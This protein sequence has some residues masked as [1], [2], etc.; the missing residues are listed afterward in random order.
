[1]P[2]SIAV[3]RVQ[4]RRERSSLRLYNLLRTGLAAFCVRRRDEKEQRDKV[5][6][7]LPHKY[8]AQME[9]HG[10]RC[11]AC[12]YLCGHVSLVSAFWARPTSVKL[13]SCCLLH[14]GKAAK[15]ALTGTSTG[16]TARQR[17]WRNLKAV[18]QH[19]RIPRGRFDWVAWFRTRGSHCHFG[20]LCLVAPTPAKL[21]LPTGQW[22]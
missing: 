13:S 5:T 11:K 17:R 20:V 8:N 18:Y 12:Q 15:I 2:R 19:R 21:P 14:L 22:I 6:Q 1:M 9:A 4:A 7:A 16:Q 3:L 10:R